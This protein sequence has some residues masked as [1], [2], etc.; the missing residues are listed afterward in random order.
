MMIFILTT[1]MAQGPRDEPVAYATLKQRDGLYYVEAR[2][3]ESKKTLD[4]MLDTGTNATIVWDAETAGGKD[5]L[6]TMDVHLGSGQIK[7]SVGLIAQPPEQLQA[8]QRGKA[9]FAGMLGASLLDGYTVGLDLK[10][11]CLAFFPKEKFLAAAKFW[12]ST[13]YVAAEKTPVRWVRNEQVLSGVEGGPYQA[14][15]LYPSLVSCR[16]EG[17]IRT[18]I[19]L[20]DARVFA[21]LDTGSD[22][23]NFQA[24]YFDDLNALKVLRTEDVKSIY[25]IQS[26]RIYSVPAISIAGVKITRV[27]AT[28]SDQFPNLVSNKVMAEFKWLFSK[29]ED[30][31]LVAA[32]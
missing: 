30:S 29:S 14:R 2:I 12:F 4:L 26:H 17:N 3:G 21:F 7:T 1:L 27:E 8:L 24:R 18:M 25:G 10:G 23:G 6:E 13:A 11:R 15:Q 20:G 19:S 22:S 32:N 28:I 31:A 9:K 5:A 16:I